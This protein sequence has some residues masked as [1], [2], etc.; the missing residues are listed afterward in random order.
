[1][2][3]YACGE[4]GTNT[5]IT[6]PLDPPVEIPEE[7][8]VDPEVPEFQTEVVVYDAKRPD[9]EPSDWA[10]FPVVNRNPNNPQW[11][12]FDFDATGAVAG[13]F[14]LGD[15]EAPG[16]EDTQLT[17]PEKNFLQQQ[18]PE[19]DMDNVEDYGDVLRVFAPKFA[20]SLGAQRAG[21]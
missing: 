8:W 19:G 5:Y 2:R 12:V 20:T 17:N 1:M 10:G 15:P 3:A 14:D 9:A 6:V 18:Y 11:F 7:D 16:W 21:W 4:I 13:T